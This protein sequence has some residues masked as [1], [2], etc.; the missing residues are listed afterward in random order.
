MG[1]HTPALGCAVLDRER[2]DDEDDHRDDECR[3]ARMFAGRNARAENRKRIRA[4]VQALGVTYRTP[5]QI[6]YN[7]EPDS[8]EAMSWFESSNANTYGSAR[9][10]EI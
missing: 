6:G 2:Y 10:R 1:G 3:L 5:L 9:M 4:Q 8:Y 7:A